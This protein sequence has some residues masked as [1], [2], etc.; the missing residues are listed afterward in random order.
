MRFSG[1]LCSVFFLLALPL[2]HA[3]QPNVEFSADTVESDM[4]GGEKTG[5]LYVGR[6]R[7][8]TEFNMGG[9]PLIQIVDLK[10]Q[11]ALMI[12]PRE[13]SYIRSRAAAGEAMAAT[14]TSAK[15][16]CA[17][18][19]N[20]TCKQ[21]GTEDVNGRAAQ[22][23]EFE[24]KVG[25]QTGSMTVWLDEQRG[26]PIRQIMPDGSGMEMRMLGEEKVAGRKAEKWELTAVG[27]DGKSSTSFQWY[28]P[29]LKMNIR[30]EADNGAFR[31]LRNIRTGSQ[32]E[33]LFR[34]PAGYEEISMPMES[35][36]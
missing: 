6:D 5:K 1:L 20:I 4:Q 14:E 13:K 17:G 23:W 12:N 29:E 32:S 18:M 34:V 24:S 3:Q 31:E 36:E 30:E 27:P 10:A 8:R 9:Q 7:V 15:N 19:Q 25:E 2:A 21:T 26:M 33:E 28:D 16:P 35:D 11:E 22:K